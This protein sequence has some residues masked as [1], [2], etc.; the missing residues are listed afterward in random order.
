[1]NNKHN[2]IEESSQGQIETLL[3][4]LF[5]DITN[6]YDLSRETYHKLSELKNNEPEPECEDDKK[7]YYET[8]VVGKL[9]Q[10]LDKIRVANN[11]SE[12]NLNKLRQLI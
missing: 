7:P 3:C 11:Q 8:S 6:S 12:S 9:Q 4:S 10:L 2:S 1:M 5:S